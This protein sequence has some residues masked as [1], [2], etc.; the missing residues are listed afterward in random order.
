MFSALIAE[1]GHNRRLTSNYT[2]TVN[3]AAIEVLVNLPQNRKYHIVNVGA[4]GVSLVV[5]KE[6]ATTAIVVTDYVLWPTDSVDIWVGLLNNV[7]PSIDGS[8][9]L[10]L[11]C[12]WGFKPLTT[13]QI[14]EISRQ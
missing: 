14:T 5:T 8:S 11:V 3:V 9:V 2:I 1:C 10:H 4:F 13:V 7:D 12:N 6:L